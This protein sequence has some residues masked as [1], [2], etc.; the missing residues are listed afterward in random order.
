MK[1]FIYACVITHS[2]RRCV[3]F[4][5]F[6]KKEKDYYRVTTWLMCNAVGFFVGH[7]FVSFY[8]GIGY[9]LY[10]SKIR[11][12]NGCGFYCGRDAFLNNNTIFFYII[13]IF[14]NAILTCHAQKLKAT[15]RFRKVIIVSRLASF[16]GVDNKRTHLFF[17]LLTT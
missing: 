7:L 16:C 4:F 3:I 8:R 9:G 14:F 5:L 1:I 10:W 6:I 17:F 15:S 12:R 2:S 13:I 11:F